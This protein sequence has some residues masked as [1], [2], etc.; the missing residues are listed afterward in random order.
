MQGAGIIPE[1]PTTRSE[2][3]FFAFPMLIAA[4]QWALAQ[5]TA[6]HQK[7]EYRARI[8]TWIVDAIILPRMDAAMGFIILDPMPN[9]Q[10]IGATLRITA[11]TVISFGRSLWTESNFP[12]QERALT[13][14]CAS[15]RN[16]QPDSTRHARSA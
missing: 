6:L 7:E 8:S 1:L 9:S 11:V 4:I 2:S 13:R 15:Q 16:P 5:S 10:T 3:R 12:W 14:S